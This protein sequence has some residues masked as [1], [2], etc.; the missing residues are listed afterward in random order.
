MNLPYWIRESTNSHITNRELPDMFYYA[1]LISLKCWKIIGKYI[2]LRQVLVFPLNFQS[3]QNFPFDITYFYSY[4][5]LRPHAHDLAVSNSLNYA[6]FWQVMQV[7]F[8]LNGCAANNYEIKQVSLKE[9]C[10]L[11][12]WSVATTTGTPGYEFESPSKT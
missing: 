10:R 1:Q 12:A 7:T 11:L 9:C 8:I 3:F 6:T 5:P 2:I 4:N